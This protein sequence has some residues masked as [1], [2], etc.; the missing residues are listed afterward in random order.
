MLKEKVQKVTGTARDSPLFSS[1]TTKDYDSKSTSPVRST[2]TEKTM[3]IVNGYI[4]FT[5][6]AAS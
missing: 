6:D 5:D 4:V 2:P 1:H 3:K